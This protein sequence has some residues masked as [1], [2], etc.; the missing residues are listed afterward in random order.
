MGVRQEIAQLRAVARDEVRLDTRRRRREV[1]KHLRLPS[2]PWRT[3]QRGEVWG[4][5]MVRNEEDVLGAVLE[6]LLEQGLDRILV[7]DNLSDDSTPALLHDYAARD[8]RILLGYDGLDAY[9]QDHKMTLLARAASRWGA[10]WIVPFDADE[11]WFAETRSVAEHLRWLG[12]SP[13]FV[14]TVGSQMHDAIP[15][16]P[17]GNWT[18]AAMSVNA[19]AAD[20]G[21]VAVRAHPTVRI[22]FGNH[23]AARYGMR[24]EGL[25]IAHVAYRNPL[26]LARKVRQGSRALKLTAHAADVG[27]HWRDMSKLSDRDVLALWQDLQAGVPHPEVGLNVGGPIVS[28]HPQ[29][30]K[31]WDPANE[32]ESRPAG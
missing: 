27:G 5:T 31:C 22:G 6:H 17:I 3:R 1:S 10:D 23:G 32:L 2:L 13:E 28:C 19:T 11:L 30:W 25:R 18:T 24:R 16:G 9:H 26:Q 12:S 29:S 21:K 8:P 4:V 7:A 15:Q 14:G 20:L